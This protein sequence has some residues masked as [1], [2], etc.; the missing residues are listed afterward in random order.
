[1]QVEFFGAARQVTGSC[2]LVHCGKSR[3]LVDCGLIQGG[4]KQEARNREAFPFDASQIDAMVLTHAHLDHSGRIPQLVEAGFSGRIYTQRATRDLC[5]I[6][7]KDAGFL[8]EKDAEIENRKRQRKHLPADVEPMYTVQQAEAA[9]RS[10]RAVDYD[11]IID[12]ADGVRLRL[13]DAGHILGSAIAE[14]WLEAGGKKRKLVFSGDLGH[15]DAPILC[16]RAH[17]EEAD[18]VVMESTYGDRLHRPWDE[19]WDE[20]GEIISS[21]KAERG[22]ILV[23]AFAVGRTQELLYVL[24]RNFDAW[25]LSDWSIFLDS[26]MAIEATKV[27][28]RH[29]GLYDDEAREQLPDR[30]NPFELPNLTLSRT[31]EDSMAI[32][33]I[34]SGA[35]V[36]AGSGMCNG[37]RIR[38]HFKH[39]LWRSSCHVIIV[40]FQAAGTPGRALVD[41]ARE[42]K[43]WGETVRVGAQIHTVGG[44]SAHAD[45]RELLAWYEG[46]RDHP[47]VALVHGEE[48][49]MDAL[50]E[51]LHRRYN[52]S[53]RTPSEG[54]AITL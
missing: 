29:R 23:P 26:P 39:N 33:R 8:A 34:Q 42:L 21:A 37:G 45:Q 51:E 48:G 24:G 4:R 35:L 7:L 2:F 52:T 22:N 32:N 47:P 1:M 18:L 41:G 20:L 49:A 25:E 54:Q 36:I 5:H 27:Y 43:L 17:V 44:L 13:R 28:A 15:A 10:F 31:T 53:V 19:T 9:M 14:L 30:K 12:I 50:A 40:G 16:D 38:H 3:V 6:M 46:F 11:Q